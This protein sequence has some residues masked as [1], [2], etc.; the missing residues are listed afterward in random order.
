MSQL[1]NSLCERINATHKE[2]ELTSDLG[3]R[4]RITK[5][6]NQMVQEFREICDEQ[7]RRF[8]AS[9]GMT[10]AE[11][12]AAKSRADIRRILKAEKRAR[13]RATIDELR[14]PFKRCK[15]SC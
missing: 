10:V 13:K 4:K 11:F 5:R 14:N 12:S 9:K 1:I 3:E 7:H 2:L 8:C 6:Y 15:L